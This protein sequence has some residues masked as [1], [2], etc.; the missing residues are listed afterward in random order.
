M[1]APKRGFPTRDEICVTQQTKMIQGVG[2]KARVVH[3]ISYEGA[4]LVKV[5]DTEDWFAQ[6]KVGNVWY[7][8]EAT[9]EFPSGSTEGSWEAGVND[10][11][12]GFIMLA[13]PQVGDRYYQECA[14]NVAEGQAKVLSRNE[15]VTMTING[16]GMT[17][18]NVLLTQ[19]TTRFDPGVVEYKYYAPGVGFIRGLIVKGGDERTELISIGTCNE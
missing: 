18:D 3:H 17:F 19:E 4:P 1:R 7:F 11:D 5:E 2:V 6:D 10:A 16:K 15:T 9:I 14:R 12:A 8:G 13:D